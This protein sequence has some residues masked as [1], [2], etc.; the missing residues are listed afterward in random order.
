MTNETPGP[1][2]PEAL[3]EQVLPGRA[4]WVR[5]T[6]LVLARPGLWLT[7]LRQAVR[8]ARPRWWARAPFVPV[9]DPDY[10][11]FRFETQYGP[12]GQP[13][14]RDLVTYREWC[15]DGGNAREAGGRRR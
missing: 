11:R 14:P 2:P 10:L 7:A 12:T 15:R 13:D 6:V 3:P 8:L 5:A 1:L 4:F 9:P